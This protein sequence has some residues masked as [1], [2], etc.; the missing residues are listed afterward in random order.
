MNV[1]R[2]E[3]TWIK[4]LPHPTC[5]IPNFVLGFLVFTDS[6]KCNL[7]IIK[8]SHLKWIYNSIDFHKFIV[9]QSL[10][11]SSIKTSLLSQT[12]PFCP[13]LVHNPMISPRQT[14]V[15]FLY[16]SIDLPFLA[17]C[18]NYAMCSLLYLLLSLTMID[19]IH[20]CCSK[21]Q[22]FI[23]F[24]LFLNYI[25]VYVCTTFCVFIHYLMYV[26]T[27]FKIW[28][29]FIKDAAMDVYMKILM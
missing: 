2:K 26:R 20:L 24:F 4:V 25:P 10:S 28:V 18:V 12:Y 23:A 5:S 17:S 27:S 15:H 11:Q 16:V 29:S 1:F 13:Q 21:F 6:L 14:Q 9:V 8:F 7:C 19:D 3:T 22:Y